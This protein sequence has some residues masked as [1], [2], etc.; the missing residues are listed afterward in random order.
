MAANRVRMGLVVALAL[1][2]LSTPTSAVTQQDGVEVQVWSIRAT[3]KNDDVSPELKPLAEA[4]KKTFKFKGYKLVKSE[5]QS[6]T[7]QATRFKLPASY[8]MDVTYQQRTN[9]KIKLKCEVIHRED[10]K[11]LKKLSTVI[12]VKPEKFQLFGG[13]TFEDEDVL[14]I[15]L[16]AKQVLS[17]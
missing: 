17:P 16:S 5:T 13:W 12:A 2:W 14:I 11:E 3:N 15:A 8:Y 7:A 10:D 1:S 4:L 6:V 9:G